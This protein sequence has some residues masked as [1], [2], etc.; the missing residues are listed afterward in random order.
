MSA[1]DERAR[2]RRNKKPEKV[3]T[4][5]DNPVLAAIKPKERY[6]FH[7]DYFQIDNSYATIMSFFHQQG[8]R[9]D[10]GAFWGIN[11][12]PGYIAPDIVTVN[13]E[14]VERMGESWI[15]EHQ[16]RAEGV[17]QMN[18]SSQSQSGT[19][20][21]RERA[22]RS[23][24]DLQTVADELNNGAS[25]LS[26]HDRILVKAPTLKKLDDAVVQIGRMYLDRFASLRAAPFPGEQHQ[27]LAHLLAK[28]ERKKG[29]GFYYTS[30]EYAGSY[31]LVTHG[32][33][34]AQGEYV[35]V[36]RG[37]VNNSAVLFDVDGWRHH[38]V[39]A[40]DQINQQRDR[41]HVADMWGAKIAQASLLNKHRVVHIVL[42][43]CKLSELGPKLEDITYR[44][45]MSHGDVN[46]FEMFGD[47]EDELSIF[48]SHMQ[49]LILMAEQGYPGTD[50]D[51]AIIH[52]S[53]RKVA[54]QFYVEQHMWRD[55]ARNHR[56]DLR[57]VG[58]DH[59]DVPTLKVF[60]AYLN[61]AYEAIKSH[62]ARDDE[63][64]HALNVL[65]GTFE[66]MLSIN[67][68]LFNTY[69]SDAIDGIRSGRR[70]IYD[71]AGLMRRDPHAAMAQ[72]VNII[73][74]AVSTLGLGDC[75]V[76]HGA[77]LVDD[78]VRAYVEQQFGHLFAL[79]GRVAYLYDDVEPCLHA[80]EF[81]HFDKAD[82][83]IFGNMTLNLAAEY[84]AS[85]GCAIPPDLKNQICARDASV[86]YIRRDFDNVV[87]EQDL[88][89]DVGMRH[90]KRRRRLRKVGKA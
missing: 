78:S 73:N 89:L 38:V 50:H 35:G 87:F 53:L 28:N 52:N 72:L 64:L 76:V 81:N 59:T 44:L 51:R 12:I 16:Q 58:L 10:Y 26:V 3:E 42:N 68:D 39:I 9:D 30:T 60:V 15:T 5:A 83:T 17:A 40:S 32:L 74:F 21:S 54:T 79:G 90:T 22:L 24:E 86:A 70:V 66:G 13:L 75:V 29:K 23:Q 7:S 45:D 84:E 25:Y 18:E 33:E 88:R 1:Q 71:F 80:Q 56:D 2:K 20:T 69:T 63:E 65:A 31:S 49:K 62:S 37:D 85:L 4:L 77:Q 47:T 55:N 82:Y 41:A 36:M 11:R 61:E 19:N 57:I 48:S 46:M 27:E 8:A 67:G 43:D 14:Q 6:V 34:D